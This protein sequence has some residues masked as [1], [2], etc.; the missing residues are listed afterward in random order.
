MKCLI[1]MLKCPRSAGRDHRDTDR[2]GDRPRQRKV[3]TGFRPVAVHGREK[4]LPRSEG[5]A[6]LRP[7]DRIQTGIDASAVLIDIPAAL[8]LPRGSDPDY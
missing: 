2:I 7:L 5:N 6:F 1:K 3:I 4:D 8:P